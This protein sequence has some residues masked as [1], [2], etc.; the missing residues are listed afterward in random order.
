MAK[1]K[2]SE[3]AVE[4]VVQCRDDKSNTYTWNEITNMVNERFN[5]D[6]KWQSVYERYHSYKKLNPAIKANTDNSPVL[7]EK[8]S[9]QPVVSSPIPPQYPQIDPAVVLLGTGMKEPSDSNIATDQVVS[10]DAE[11]SKIEALRKRFTGKQ[12]TRL[13]EPVFKHN[14]T[15]DP[16]LL[17]LLNITT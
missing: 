10:D 6:M 4:F 3:L 9:E 15:L 13:G 5:I 17:N 11:A 1:R 2:L 12:R 16:E 7:V 8:G 14:E